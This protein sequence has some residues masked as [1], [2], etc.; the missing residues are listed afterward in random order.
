VV[1]RVSVALA[2]L[3]VLAPAHAAH[4]EYR[5]KIEI[6]H[7]DDFARER[8][9]TRYRLITPGG[10]KLPLTL[11]RAPRTP[12]GSRV[13]VRG[14]RYGSHIRGRVLARG[15]VH[16]AGV[17]AGP[18]KTAVILLNFATDTRTPWTPDTV[19]QRVFTNANSTSAF[20]SEESYGD[21]SLTG[22]LHSDGDV[23]GWYTLDTPTA[24]CDV[25]AWAAQAKDAAAAYGFSAAGYDHIVYAFPSQSSCG[26]WA[27]LGEL[28]G[29]QSWMNG[30]ISTRVVAH[31]LGHNMGLHHA[32]SLTCTAGGT[33]VAYSP[34]ST[35]T[36]D[37]YG[38]PF[39]V[40]G[41]S[42]RH[43]NAWHLRQIG[44]LTSSNV[45]T[46]SA[47][48]SYTL[49]SAI[50]RGEAGQTQLLRVPITG[51]SPRRYYDLEV[52]GTGGVFDNFLS[53]SPAV[54][55]V[56]IH[57]DP[58]P[59]VITQ[60][61][62]IDAT[63]GSPS[64]FS[65]APLAPGATFSDGS[66][67]ITVGSVSG[68]TATVDVVT[69]PPPDTTPPSVPGPVSAVPAADRV[70]LSWPESSDDVGVS[71]YRV[72]RNNVVKATVAS[73]GWVDTTVIPGQSYQYKVAALDAAGNVATSPA[74]VATV[75]AP[76]PEPPASTSSSASSSSS[77][78]LTGPAPTADPLGGGTYEPPIGTTTPPSSIR[79][80][81]P[82]VARIAY[83]VQHA[84]LPRSR[85]LLAYANDANG[86]VRLE[87]LVDGKRRKSV[88]G[89]SVRWPMK[90]LRRG[91]HLILVRA[92]DAA[93]N[94]G[95]ASVRVRIVR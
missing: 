10:R 17:T 54:N 4:A 62:L 21:V 67:S 48:G 9:Q 64:G 53:T 47:S 42:A 50:A 11:A 29:S 73:P 51:T 87:V 65:D 58:D 84:R 45:A 32:S 56:T 57:M 6:R 89:R 35:C 66:V 13:I 18:R 20:Y 52:R 30:D 34:S 69:G 41:S 88:A 71:G 7:S 82:P 16:A 60:S 92:Y 2:A 23:F 68:A 93:G 86:V 43:N 8:T 95:K 85:T 76:P 26:G 3:A 27:G 12:S 36:P 94:H 22:K 81:I 33:V 31:E 90:S 28:P 55:G 14:R 74:V 15:I 80:T 38:D 77:S 37:E 19:R 59:S 75:P 91:Q 39:D 5:G 78:T 70:T 83:P 46:A 49:T 25:D 79:D 1:R 63:P 72:Y 40:M 44:F 61:E 24:G